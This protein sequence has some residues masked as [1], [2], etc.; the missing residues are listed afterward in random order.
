MGVAVCKGIA[1]YYGGKEKEAMTMLKEEVYSISEEF[2]RGLYLIDEILD[3]YL[4]TRE[5][6]RQYQDVLM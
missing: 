3:I 5:K 6:I 2:G 4:D 1:L